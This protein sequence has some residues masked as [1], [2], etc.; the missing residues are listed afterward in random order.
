MDPATE[1]RVYLVFKEGDR[2]QILGLDEGAEIVFGRSAEATVQLQ[3]GTASREH[4]RIIR[5]HGLQL[6]DLGSRNGTRLNDEVV[7]G[8]TRA[9]RS[10]DVVSIGAAS[11]LVA[12]TAGL[13]RSEAPTRLGLELERLVASCGR[14]S[15][16]RLAVDAAGLREILPTLGAA[17][18]IE[19]Q[20]D[21]DYAL[22]VADASDAA[23]LT[24]Q[25]AKTAPHVRVTVAHAPADGATAGELWAR[26]EKPQTTTAPPRPSLPVGVI[27]GDPAM[28]KLF[29]LLRKVA[30]TPTT[31]LILGET[32][33]GKEVVAEQLHQQSRRDKGPF[34]RL[35]CGS[36]PETL[37][38]SELFGYEKGAFTGADRRKS[39][40]IEA[41]DGGTLFLD[42]IGELPMPM[43]T[44]LLRVLEDHKL[45]RVGGREELTIDVRIIAATNRK[46][47]EEVAAGRFRAD[48]YFRLS[49]FVLRLP[50]LRERLG[51]L[52][53]LAELFARQFA[54]RMGVRPPAISPAAMQLLRHHRWPGNIRELRNTIEHALVVADG[55]DIG[56]EQ[57]PE[58]FLR[59]EPDVAVSGPMRS[60]VADVERRRIQEAMDAEGGNQTRAAKRLGIS[61]R[62]L[63][64]KLEKYDLRR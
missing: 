1:T 64:Y 38:E 53:L 21:G 35:N 39:G 57:L 42:E 49:A 48:L 23:R 33:A 5:Q 58:G 54:R 8:K 9:L 15:L 56:V 31:V 2:T 18:S 44:R 62:A 41:A 20:P 47:D 59:V 27:V 22:L 17:V 61:R 30:P 34:V 45:I 24:D 13:T 46:L 28:V 12:E 14:A 43:Q 55:G 37:L 6:V 19:A 29:E 10:G 26:C 60:E 51:E 32:G 16:L 25:L 11:I 63:Q 7:R 3:D 40:Y 4:A 36:L 50:P 52:E